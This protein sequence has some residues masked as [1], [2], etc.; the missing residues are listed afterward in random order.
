ML[1]ENLKPPKRARNSWHNQV[2]QKKKEREKESGQDSLSW[3][4]LW[5][6]KGTHT[7]RSNLTNRKIS[8][9]RGIS[10][11][12]KKAQQKAWEL[13]SRVREAQIIWT[14]GTDT[15]AWD[16]RSGGVAGHWDLGSGTV[17]SSL[18]AHGGQPCGWQEQTTA[19]IPDSRGGV[20]Y[21]SWGYLNKNYLQTQPF[22]RVS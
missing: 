10:N 20:A 14:A 15:T 22:Q 21:H 9:V 13:K 18:L 11:I 16:S 19:I 2:E 8:W 1:A 3:R 6:W 17:R 4:E 7:L 5:R 12:L